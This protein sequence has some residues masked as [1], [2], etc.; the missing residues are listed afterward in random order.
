M[1]DQTEIIL[2]G[3]LDGKQRNRVKGLLDM[4]YSPKELA[5]EVGFTIDQVYRVY[6]PG[7]CPNVR[8]EWGHILI[9]GKTFKLWFEENYKKH[10]LEEGQAF[11]L[12][13]RKAVMMINPVRKQKDQ[14]FYDICDCPNCGR[15]LTRIIDQKR[16]KHD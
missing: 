13:C 4:L 3:R 16:R 9:N 1:N 5:E 14:L 2:S 6:V 7:G 15:K 10:H 8:D 12:T 11:C